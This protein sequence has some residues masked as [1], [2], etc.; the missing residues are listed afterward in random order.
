M[1]GYQ[2][3]V[4]VHA[5]VATVW[6]V[7]RDVEAWPQ[8]SPTMEDV[9]VTAGGPVVVGSTARVRQPRL[10]P[11]TWVVDHLVDGQRFCWHTR[12]PGYRLIADH[13]LDALP[14]DAG[15]GVRLTVTMTG[16]LAWLVW[17][18]G[19]RTIRSYVDQEAA[20]LKRRCETN[21]A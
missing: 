18:L 4:T 9:T 17:L 7:T 2:T 13:L 12:G 10:R 6:Q 1:P 3:S 11:T 14:D 19:G 15:T 21:P 5:P 16:P 20:A 8:W